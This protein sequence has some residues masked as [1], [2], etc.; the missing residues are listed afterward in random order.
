MGVLI[1]SFA[2]CV[3]YTQRNPSASFY[4]LPFR[5]WELLVGSVLAVRMPKCPSL[6]ARDS[7]SG[8]GLVSLF[9]AIIL[10]DEATEF[11]G[12][13][14]ALP[15]V[16]SALI[17]AF[18]AD[19]HVGQW[20]SSRPLVFTGLLSYSLYLWHWP[21]IVFF[22]DWGL[23]ETVSGRLGVV[24]L[25][26]VMA[27][28]SWKYIETPFRAPGYWPRPRLFGFAAMGSGIL[29]AMAIGLYLTD[30]WPGRFSSEDVAF[31][32]ARGDIS[33]DRQRC[34]I[35]GGTPDLKS[36]CR[37]GAHEGIEPDTLIWGDSHGVE[38]AAALA[39]AGLPIIQAT[40]SS[41]PPALGYKDTE[42]PQ[43]DE[44]NNQMV[45]ALEHSP[46]IKTVVLAAYFIA[47]DSPKF[48]QGMQ[49][50]I[51]RLKSAGKTV[52][53]L[54]PLPN[55]GRN[56]PSYLAFGNRDPLTPKPVPNAFSNYTAGVTVID[57]IE[58]LC[59]D[60]PCQPIVAG[61]PLLFDHSHLSMTGARS[62]AHNVV[63][64]IRRAQRAPND[65]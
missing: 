62:I 60:G 10:Y 63:R 48:W 44:H 64:E 26:F 27:W 33:P 51:A 57:V 65:L 9:A 21:L 13:A 40:Y 39:E 11:P 50:T 38:L 22:H 18:S 58:K 43:C 56:I 15:V 34:H 3:V 45:E 25:S 52:I 2:L 55:F 28:V 36:L 7:L 12:Y 20:L 46:Q 16:G 61:K 42:R 4:L 24:V 53:V 1:V 54:G 19:S 47:K 29:G 5:A 41:C 35:N 59:P 14:A 30:G 8:L 23:L 32:V 37:L 31:D 6:I 17:I 49:L